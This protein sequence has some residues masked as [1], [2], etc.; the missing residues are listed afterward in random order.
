MVEDKETKTE[1]AAQSRPVQ[2]VFVFNGPLPQEF[3][4]A[5]ATLANTLNVATGAGAPKASTAAHEPQP[6][7]EEDPWLGMDD[8]AKYL[9]VTKSTMYKYAHERTIE[10]RKVCGK[11][12]FRRSA[13]DLF[14]NEHVRPARQPRPKR[15]RIALAFGSGT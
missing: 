14:L 9:G 13:L 4:P 3:Q 12:Q 6:P 15:R 7:I 10:H 5:I 1:E 8:S 2:L 11:L